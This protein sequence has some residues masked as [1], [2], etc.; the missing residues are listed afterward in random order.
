MHH[1]HNMSDSATR[2]LLSL[3]D[4][5][6]VRSRLAACITMLDNR[7]AACITMLDNRLAACMTHTSRQTMQHQDRVTKPLLVDV[8]LWQ[9]TQRANS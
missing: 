4:T 2:R 1:T 5:L 7:L 8:K 6:A 3:S 9:Q